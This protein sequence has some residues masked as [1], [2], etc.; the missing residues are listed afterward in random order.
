VHK[1]PVTNDRW[2]LVISSTI[3]QVVVVLKTS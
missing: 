2:L 1:V 3:K